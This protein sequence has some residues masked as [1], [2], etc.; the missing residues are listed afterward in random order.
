VRGKGGRTNRDGSC[1]A[2]RLYSAKHHE[3]RKVLAQGQADVGEQVDEKGTDEGDAAASRVA[4]GAPE[5]RCDALDNHVDG[6]MAVI[7]ISYGCC[8]CFLLLLHESHCQA[9]SSTWNTRML[10]VVKGGGTEKGA[11]KQCD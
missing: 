10:G 9:G 11:S 3:G 1:A 4:E 7:R 5:G 6:L 2:G 8:C